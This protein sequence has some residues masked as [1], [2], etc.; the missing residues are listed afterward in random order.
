MVNDEQRS[1]DVSTQPN[2]Y[3]AELSK[4]TTTGKEDDVEDVNDDNIGWR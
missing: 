3:Y 4:T 1:N 2:I